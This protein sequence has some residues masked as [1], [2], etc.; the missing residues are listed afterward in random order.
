MVNNR[1]SRNSVDRILIPLSVLIFSYTLVRAYLLSITWDE[2]YTY[3][4]FVNRGIIFPHN[5]SVMS[6]NNHLL[7]TWLEIF[8]VK[9]FG[10]NEFVLRLPSLAGHF[11]FLFF[12]LKLVR[13]FEIKGFA[14]AAFLVINLNPYLLDFFS[15]ARGYG[16]SMGLLMGS[17]YFLNLFIQLGNKN[18][19]A[20]LS[21]LFASLAV[22]ANITL[23]NYYLL[24][25]CILI[26]LTAYLIGNSKPV[27]E[28][29][30]KVFFSVLLFPIGISILF[31]FFVLPYIF[32]L[33]DGGAFFYGG[34]TGFYADTF[35]ETLNRLFYEIGNWNWVMWITKITVAL[36]FLV[37]IILT[38]RG[39][40]KKQITGRKL[41]FASLLFLSIFG[42]ILSIVQHYWFGI[43]YLIGR[44]ALHLVVLF[45][46]GIVFFLREMTN[47]KLLSIFYLFTLLIITHFIFTVN[48]NS[49][50]DW[51][52][53]AETK[54]VVSDLQEINNK[55]ISTSIAISSSLEL[56]EPIEYY[57]EI[58]K[59][60]WLNNILFT[61]NINV[62]ATYFY[63]TKIDFEKMPEN[64]FEI[65]EKYPLSETV[66]ARRKWKSSPSFNF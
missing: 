17:I 7:N 18:K 38:T 28:N 23:L 63:L 32:H 34:K 8:L 14:I 46:L 20:I 45:T 53:N 24:L 47:V 64:T 25:I 36:I 1:L 65:I 42:G 57:K 61:E 5:F 10:V 52:S 50:Y 37:G 6:A 4:E 26:F 31:L 3:L 49:V 62:E 54:E 22:L 59:M 48:F 2:A 43:P 41:F 33:K 55:T 35:S 13:N 19:N 39:F 21:V 16:L 60:D 30:L 58:N 27:F 51:K 44:T 40:I 56:S 66:L 15:L 9:C 12:S 11:L 29:K